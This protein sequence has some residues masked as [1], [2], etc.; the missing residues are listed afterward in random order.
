M[1][2]SFIVNT[3]RG[4]MK[5][6][7]IKRG[8]EEVI[9]EKELEARIKS[10]KKLRIKF[11]VDPSS[12]D[13]H[14][15]HAVVLRKLKQ[16]QGEGHKIIFL[17]GDYTAMI[18]D[19]SGKNK[20]RPVLS[21]SQISAN[22]KTYF[23]QVGKI[24]DIKKAEIRRNSEWFKKTSLKEFINLG[25]KFSVSSI[26]ERNDFE[27]R[28]SEGREI[29]MHE[30]YYPMMQA[31]DSVML[32]A[33]IEFGGT[34]QRF[35]MLAGRE[36]Q[37][38]TGQSPQIVI[39]TKILVGTDGKEKMSK[40]LGNYIGV[41][42]GPKEQF[43]KIMSIPD[44]LIEQYFE[45][46]TGVDSQ[47]IT[48]MISEMKAGK[49]P[50]DY[51]LK[52]AREIATIYHGESEAAYAEEQF[53]NQFQKKEIPDEIPAVKLLGD[54]QLMLLLIEIGAAESNAGARRLIEQGGVKIDGAK[55]TEANTQ[56]STHKG[57]II[58]V[59]KRKFWRIK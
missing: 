21:E 39:T 16:F 17:I 47:E 41:A 34:D 23:N 27:K 52:L 37:K 29:S 53:I 40:S 3:K 5:T 2:D 49:N 6:E 30:L 4:Y 58:Q 51:K 22:A 24:I 55:I 46:C 28:L 57:M 10:G 50:R 36:L 14:L 12:P 44:G 56:I 19:P 35:N 48:K 42:E 32:E 18:G 33:D 7:L 59:G 26:I 25:S 13:I 31:Y 45:L 15:G 1:L 54:Y 43:G 38:K 9:S 20:T 8:I 11:G